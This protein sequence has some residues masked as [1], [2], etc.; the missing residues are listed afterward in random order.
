LL[1]DP[2]VTHGPLINR[3]GVTKTRQHIDDAL[4]K[5]AKLVV[6]GEVRDDLDRYFIE[7][8]LITGAKQ[9][10]LVAK[11]ETFGP[12]APVFM[13]ETEEEVVSMANDTEFG[14]AGYFFSNELRRVWRVAKALEVGMVGVNTGKISAAESPFGGIKESGLGKEG[15][16]YGLAE[17]QVMKS[18]TLGNL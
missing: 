11:E 17:F 16:K 4:S 15:S 10:M 9:N 3:T 8:A 6:G 5:G 1:L 13:F 14:L 18:V 7:P 12:L 2:S